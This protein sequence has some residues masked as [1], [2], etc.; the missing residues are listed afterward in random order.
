MPHA[1][2]GKKVKASFHFRRDSGELL[3]SWRIAGPSNQ[4]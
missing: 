4:G 2:R 3:L 1:S